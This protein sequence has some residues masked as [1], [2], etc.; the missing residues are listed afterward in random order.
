[1]SDDKTLPFKQ[2]RWIGPI[3]VPE[4]LRNRWASRIAGMGRDRQD[5]IEAL[6]GLYADDIG[7]IVRA[8]ENR[9]GKCQMKRNE[10]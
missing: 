1:M 2:Y 4:E 7:D 9:I 5:V 10:E 6:V 3:R 8:V